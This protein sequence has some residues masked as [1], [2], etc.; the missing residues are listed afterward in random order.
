M[1]PSKM[2]KKL[3]NFPNLFN[4][5]GNGLNQSY[6]CIIKKKIFTPL[7]LQYKEMVKFAAAQTG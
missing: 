4:N 1:A 7:S 5:S 6:L 2:S 3:L